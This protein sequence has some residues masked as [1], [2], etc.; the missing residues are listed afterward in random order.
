MIGVVLVTHGRLADELKAA[1]EHVVGPQ[2]LFRT[3]CIGPQDDMEVRR[4]DILD[5]IKEQLQAET[6]KNL[7][8][9]PVERLADRFVN[10][11][12]DRYRND[13]KK[14]LKSP[15]F[16]HE[17]E[18]EEVDQ[19][20][21]DSEAIKG[22]I[23]ALPPEQRDAVKN[24][25]LSEL[26]D[27]GLGNEAGFGQYFTMGL[28]LLNPGGLLNQGPK[29]RQILSKRYAAATRGLYQYLSGE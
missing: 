19:F 24:E 6:G 23:E 13:L 14:F 28:D 17:D 1:T 5:A 27:A 16:F 4:E 7:S 25:V 9:Y 2:T 21:K 29:K 3:V 10:D 15:Q 12:L 8:L 11:D 18:F 20:I 26:G 22:H